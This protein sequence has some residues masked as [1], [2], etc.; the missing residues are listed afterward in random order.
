[1]KRKLEEHD[2]R[3]HE[4]QRIAMD[5]M[6]QKHE[7]KVKLALENDRIERDGDLRS[8]TRLARQFTSQLEKVEVDLL[9]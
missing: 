5:R 9:L 3:A 6:E 8:Q 4:K 2:A 1:M 7:R